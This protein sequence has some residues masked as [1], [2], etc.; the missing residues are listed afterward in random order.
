M[1]SKDIGCSMCSTEQVDGEFVVVR[2]AGFTGSGRIQHP[3]THF[4]QPLNMSL[5]LGAGTCSSEL[6][7]MWWGGTCC[8]LNTHNKHELAFPVTWGFRVSMG[9]CSAQHSAFQN[10]QPVN[11]CTSC[12]ASLATFSLHISTGRAPGPVLVPVL[13]PVLAQFWSQC[14]S[15]CWSQIW[16]Q[17]RWSQCWSQFWA[18][19]CFQCWSHFWSHF[20]SQCWSQFQSQFYSQFWSQFGSQF[21][22]PSTHSKNMLR[23]LF[24]A[25]DD[26]RGWRFV[27]KGPNLVPVLKNPNH[28]TLLRHVLGFPRQAQGLDPLCK[29]S[30]LFCGTGHPTECWRCMKRPVL[31]L[32]TTPSILAFAISAGL[33]RHCRH[34]MKRQ[35]LVL[36]KTLKTFAASVGLSRGCRL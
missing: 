14:W 4:V 19:F 1:Y 31:V 30:I 25:A 23:C 17:C 32:L 8:P 15:Q 34:C 28:A 10:K 33:P 36:E 13:V 21:W 5:S 12:V 7:T 20:W 35:A 26:L 9:M 2:M 22:C 24:C 29:A 18:P 11:R 3:V 27:I 6:L 16:S